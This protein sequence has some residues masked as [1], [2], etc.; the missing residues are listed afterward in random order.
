[1]DTVLDTMACCPTFLD[2]NTAGD[3]GS[4]L[5][6]EGVVAWAALVMVGKFKLMGDRRTSNQ[7]ANGLCGVLYSDIAIR[8]YGLVQ[9]LS[10]S[11]HV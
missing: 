1:M 5:T 6:L 11:T 9:V 8:F 10:L 3:V 2:V 4:E 7:L